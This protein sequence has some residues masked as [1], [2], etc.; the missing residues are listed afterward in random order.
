MSMMISK[1]LSV[2]SET[3]ILSSLEVVLVTKQV[4]V[5]GDHVPWSCELA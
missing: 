5:K 4:L 1:R 3:T 2:M